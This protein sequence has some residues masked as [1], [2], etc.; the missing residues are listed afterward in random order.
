VGLKDLFSKEGRARSAMQKNLARAINKNAQPF[1]R[2]KSLESLIDEGS[3]EALV[4]LLRRFDMTYDK[5]IEDEKEKN[6][7]YERLRAKGDALLPALREGIKNAQSYAWPLRLAED[8]AKGDQLLG[9]IDDLLKRHPAGY[10]RDPSR[11]IQLVQWIGELNLAASQVAPRLRPYI[12]DVDEGVRFQTVGA[13]K[14]HKDEASSR[15]PLLERF[16]NPDEESLRLR[17][18]ILELFAEAG[19]QVT[20]YRPKVEER[21]PEQFMLDAKGFV[22]KK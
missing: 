19:W 20:G 6:Y 7:V 12:D 8:V 9:L 21:L 2:M 11:K 16:V 15:V 14:A 18:H 5:S 17:L 22:K 13:L 1:D 4:G 10:E 3:Q